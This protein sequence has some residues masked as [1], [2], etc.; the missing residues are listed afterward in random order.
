MTELDAE[1][2]DLLGA[3]AALDDSLADHTLEQRSRRLSYI[4][5]ALRSLLYGKP[6]YSPA[7]TAAMLRVRAIEDD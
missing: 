7:E 5:L 6:G 4:G 2:R 3:I 1:M